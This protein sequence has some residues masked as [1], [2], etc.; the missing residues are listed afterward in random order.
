MS[1]EKTEGYD[2]AMRAY[3]ANVTPRGQELRTLE[4]WVDGSQYAGRPDWFAD[5]KKPLWERAPCVVYPIVRSAID[6]NADLL[7]GDTRFPC[8]TTEAFEGEPK[9]SEDFEK[10]I[11]KIVQQARLAAASRE[12]FSAGQGSRS[13]CAIFCIRGGRLCIETARAW[14][15]TPTL[16]AEGAV[17]KLEIQYP[18]MTVVDV[19]GT[20]TAKA[21]LY[22]RVIDAKSDVTFAPAEAREDRVQPTWTA[23]TTIEHGL[24]FCPVVWYAHIKGCAPYGDVDGRAIHEHLTDEIQ[25]H[26]FALSQ[27]HRAA[28]YTGDPQWTECGVE[29]GYSPTE[30]VRKADAIATMSGGKVSEGNRPVGAYRSSSPRGKARKKTPGTVWQYESETT[31]VELHCL[32]GD[33]LDA[34]DKH[35]RDLRTKIAESLGVVFVDPENLPHGMTLSGRALEALKARQ[36]DRCDYYRADFGDHFLLPAIGM[37][38]RI[39]IAK[40]LVVEGIDAVK[41]AIAKAAENWS[42]RM[43]PIG[44]SWGRYFRLDADEEQK[45]VQLV[46]AAKDAGVATRRACVEKLNGVFDYKDVDQVLEELDDEADEA[47]QRQQEIAA[48][49]MMGAAD[50]GS[51][52]GGAGA[53]PPRRRGPGPARTKNRQ[54]AAEDGA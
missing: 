7:L 31:K 15:C 19:Q 23:Q 45:T 41:K 47:M 3:K 50:G 12:V 18:Y 25:A 38:I 8:A 46:A 37:L 33:A 1:I 24:G 29:P 32:P 22:R 51:D 13:A 28:L 48:D 4:A 49:M 2:A 53:R 39:V 36:L 34:L 30:P 52:N 20:P 10:A 26:D 9:D 6:S 27:R 5:D 35:A 16:D 43:P 17:T 44:L 40:N 11:K 54:G 14:W 21:M 42:W